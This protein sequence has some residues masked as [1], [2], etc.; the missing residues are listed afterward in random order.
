MGATVGLKVIE[1][2]ALPPS[3]AVR[4]Q[5]E[6]SYATGRIVNCTVARGKGASV[7][8][9]AFDAGQELGEHTSAGDAIVQVLEGALALTIAGERVLAAAGETVLMPAGTPHAVAAA[10]RSKM[11]LTIVRPLP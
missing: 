10:E 7:M 5:E 2:A 4:L 11:L 8:L 1:G 9:L 3:R 6:L